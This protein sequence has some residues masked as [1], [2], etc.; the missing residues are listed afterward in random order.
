MRQLKSAQIS[1]GVNERYGQLHSL[2]IGPTGVTG[3]Y[4]AAIFAHA[5]WTTVF[6]DV[7]AQQTEPAAAVYPQRAANRAGGAIVFD[8]R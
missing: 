7:L 5:N 6:A 8:R 3:G 2:A 1:L 4:A